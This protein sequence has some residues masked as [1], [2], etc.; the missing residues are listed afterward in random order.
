MSPVQIELLLKIYY[1]GE[2][3]AINSNRLRLAVNFFIHH[4]MIQETQPSKEKKD[5]QYEL[6]EKG[7]FYVKSLMAI[8]MPVS[9]TIWVLPI[10]GDTSHDEQT[11]V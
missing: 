11:C 4:E 1:S 8:P 5:P 9:K 10:E 7:D 6:T 2:M 3:V